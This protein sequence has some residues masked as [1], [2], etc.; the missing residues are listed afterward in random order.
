MDIQPPRI[1][2]PSNDQVRFRQGLDDQIKKDT[3]KTS[4]GPPALPLERDL[5]SQLED[6]PMVGQSRG[7]RG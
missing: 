7:W 4:I 6:V 5:E 2:T 3:S 1:P